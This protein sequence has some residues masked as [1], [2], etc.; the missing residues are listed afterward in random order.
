MQDKISKKIGQKYFWDVDPSTLDLTKN[1]EYIIARI[2]EYGDPE[3]IH[4]M[5]AKF[6]QKK[7]RDV[8]KTHRGFSPRTIYFWK[9]FFDLRENQILCLKKP[10]LETQKRLWPY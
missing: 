4:W 5:F 10:Y 1:S 3:A 6:D 2:L 8:F 9:S 7:I